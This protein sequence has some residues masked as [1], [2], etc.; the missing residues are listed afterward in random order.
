MP[1]KQTRAAR[2]AL[3]PVAVSGFGAGFIA[4]CVVAAWILAG[5]A[6]PGAP[7]LAGQAGSWIFAE[8]LDGRRQ[9]VAYA[10][11]PLPDGGTELSFDNTREAHRIGLDPEGNT[12][13]W[14]FVRHGTQDRAR[15]SRQGQ[16]LVVTGRLA[17]R[18]VEQRQSLQGLPWYQAPDRQL[19]S[20]ARGQAGQGRQFWTVD[21]DELK[22]HRMEA[23]HRGFQELVV[24]GRTWQ[25]ARIVVT[26]TG[27]SELFWNNQFWYDPAS[28][29]YLKFVGRRGPPW[30]P[31]L[32]MEFVREEKKP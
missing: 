7:G 6:G 8:R 24:A 2:M 17:G 4:K 19:A 3:Q 22:I 15:A 18:E 14:D 30:T 9:Q 23:V 1:R 27:L 32:E 11:R 21:L 25:A 28:G 12:R 31:L 20:L 16:D 13:D 29:Q 10:S 26:L 5:L